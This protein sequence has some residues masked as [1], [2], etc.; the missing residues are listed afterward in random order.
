MKNIKIIYLIALLISIFYSCDTEIDFSDKALNPSLV[1]NAFIE[2][3]S[4]ITVFLYQTTSINATDS[5][6]YVTNAIIKLFEDDIEKDQLVLKSNLYVNTNNGYSETHG[7]DTLYYYSSQTIAQIGKTYRLEISAPNFDNVSSETSIPSPVEIISIDTSSIKRDN[8]DWID[9]Q[10]NFTIRFKDPADEVN[11]YRLIKTNTN[12]TYSLET[13]HFENYDSTNARIMISNYSYSYFNSNDPILSFGNEDANS[14]ILGSSWNDYG[15][16]TDERINGQ[17]YELEIYESI[18][19]NGDYENQYDYSIGEFNRTNFILQSITRE[20]YL[21]LKSIDEQSFNN[22]IPFV[23][24][25]PVFSN[26]KNG[27]GIMS[28]YSSSTKSITNGEY[29]MGGIIYV[30]EN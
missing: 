9:Y 4:I 17:D 20:T 29:P 8:G 22:D 10:K 1:V 30:F 26:I 23:E 7:Y 24:P 27:V 28:G 2:N 12:G 25:V 14:Y 21:F 13:Y 16:F 5:K 3:D 11:Y 6:F 18:G 15:I 19:Y